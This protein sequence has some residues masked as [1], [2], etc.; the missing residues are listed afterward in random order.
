MNERLKL[1][2]IVIALSLLGGCQD[3][4]EDLSAYVAKVKSQQKSDIPPIPVMKPYEKFEY[5][6]A[7]LRDPFVPT[8]IDV[9]E[10]ELAP[11][12]DNGITPDS[13]RRK[14]ALEAFELSELQFV[15]TLEQEQIW[16]LVRAPDGVIHRVQNGNYMGRNHGK[17]LS[18]SE[19]ELTLKE[20]VPSGRGGFIERDTSVSAVEVK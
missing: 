6:A 8:V 3:E 14:E 5:A 11:V 17:I 18:I 10:P 15:G 1:S 7:K 4:K 16:A 20:I 9:S 2:I 13:N 19:A 12:A